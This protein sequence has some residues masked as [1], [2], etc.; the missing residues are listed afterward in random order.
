VKYLAH[1]VVVGVFVL[2]AG[3]ACG[4]PAATAQSPTLEGCPIFPVDNVWNTPVD[5]L[6]VDSS[7]AAYVGSI[8]AS[9]GFHPDFGSDPT[10]GIPYVVV[11]AS[12]AGTSVTFEYADE[13][14]AGPYPIPNNPPIEAGGDRHILI[15][16]QGECKLYELYA[17]ERIG[18][19][20][21]AGSGAIFDL[22]ANALR[23]DTWTS[24]DAAGLPIL[25]GLARLAEVQA[26]EIDHALRFTAA[27][28]RKAHVWPA[29][30]DASDI[31]DANVPPMGQRFR[32]KAGFDISSFPADAQVILRALKKYGMILADNG[33]NWFVSGEPNA[34]WDDDALNALKRLRGS[35]FE[36]VDTTSLIVGPNSAQAN[37]NR[38]DV[39]PRAAR[40]GQQATYTIEFAG[41]GA[42]QSMSDPL[43]PGMSLVAG[44]TTEPA[45][46]P[47]AVG[48]GGAITWAGSPP[49]SVLVRISYTVRIDTP[50]TARLTNTATLTGTGGSKP[51]AI[52]MIANPIQS[53]LPLAR[54]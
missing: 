35:D 3:I 29:R 42:A 40:E 10:Y 9:A 11:P 54:R 20:W 50:A 45:S 47:P 38:K 28:T 12:L 7:S 53:F 14:D 2:A 33:S 49:V 15:V 36:A 13:S 39:T 27:R 17:A 44:P 51:L 30:H 21:H 5:T 46:V 41:A 25:P 43:P 1:V 18:G 16:R 37:R 4:G 32:L 48:G 8:G 24:A 22:R 6:P 31:A 34:G 19:A 23:P 52:S 26:G